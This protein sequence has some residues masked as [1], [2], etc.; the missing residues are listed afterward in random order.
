MKPADKYNR[1][2]RDGMGT[3]NDCKYHAM[4][5]YNHQCKNPSKP[6]TW[7][8]YINETYARAYHECCV[9]FKDEDVGQRKGQQRFE[10]EEVPEQFDDYY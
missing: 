9:L 1:P 4:S 5:G 2:V 6:D 10:V 3:C 7:Q 8:N